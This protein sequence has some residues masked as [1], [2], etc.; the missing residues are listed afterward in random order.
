[1]P[2]KTIPK[3]LHLDRRAAQLLRLP[4]AAGNDDDMLTTEQVA[5]W[6]GVAKVTLELARSKGFGGPPFS[7]YFSRVKYPRGGVKAFLRERMHTGTSEYRGRAGNGA[8]PVSVAAAEQARR[9]ENARL[10]RT[11]VYGFIRRAP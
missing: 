1:M 4:E 2:G 11:P 3:S 9:Q 5:H 10:G 8:A 7:K 6:L